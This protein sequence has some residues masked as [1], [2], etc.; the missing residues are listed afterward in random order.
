MTKIPDQLMDSVITAANSALGAALDLK[1]E[2]KD[3]VKT[4]VCDG[5]DKLDIV[6]RHDYEILQ[7]Q[8]RD[9]YNRVEQLEKMVN[10]NN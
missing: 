2:S 7:D 10:P 3:L 9:L 8:V 5:L 1:Q 6:S 4:A